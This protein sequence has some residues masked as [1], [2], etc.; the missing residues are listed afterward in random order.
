MFAITLDWLRNLHAADRIALAIG[1]LQS[2]VLYYTVHI[3][4]RASRQQMRAYICV[5]PNFIYSF[6]EKSTARFRFEIRN[7]GATPAR[8]VSHRSGVAV[9]PTTLPPGFI[10]PKLDAPGSAPTALFP[11]APIFGCAAAKAPF[12]E[13]EISKVKSREG[14]IYVFGLVTYRDVFKRRQWTRFAAS[15]Q[16]DDATIAALTSRYEPEDLKVTFQ[17]AQVGNDVK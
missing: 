13:A 6:D 7:V 4:R 10:F 14:G 3:A 11:D 17:Y 5:T 15:V 8:L 16:A 12:T 9:L 1:V 2:V